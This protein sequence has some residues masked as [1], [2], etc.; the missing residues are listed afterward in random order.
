MEESLLVAENVRRVFREPGAGLEVLKG[1]DLT[2]NRA[3]IVFILGRSG[4]GKSTLLH[5]LASLDRPT[6][7]RVIFRGRD[8]GTFSEKEL[9]K[10]RNQRL[11]FIFQFYYLLPELNLLENVML[12]A[13]MAGKK[14]AKKSAR[15]LLEKVGLANRAGH[16]PSQLSGGEQQRAAIARALVNEPDIVF[17]DEPTGNLDEETADQVWKLLLDLNRR[18]GQTLC[19]VTHDENLV[20]TGARVH[21]L[22]EGRLTLRA[23]NKV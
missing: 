12:P 4:A 2:I 10:Y 8:L 11:G 20:E 18:E 21:Y 3:E 1:V 5:I 9:A 7:G 13:R 6:E 23:F 15:G 19:V 16:F 17:C 14:D 22:H